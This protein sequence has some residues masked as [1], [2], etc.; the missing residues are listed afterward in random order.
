MAESEEDKKKRSL[1]EKTW[2]AASTVV[3]AFYR[4]ALMPALEKLIPQGASEL[5]NAL[6][7]GHAY[8]PYGTTQRPVKSPEEVEHGV[9]GPPET[10]EERAKER[11]AF[12]EAT[13]AERTRRQVDKDVA[14]M[15][16]EEQHYARNFRSFD[17][18]PYST[19]EMER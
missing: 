13:S 14:D 10:I 11:V 5:A 12:E 17:P 3:R 8:M 6:F 19:M 9:H 1:G 4:E 18:P 7:Q 2:D 15:S 16:P